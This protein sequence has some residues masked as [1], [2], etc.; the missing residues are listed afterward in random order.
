MDLVDGSN[1]WIDWKGA[2]DG[3]RAGWMDGLE[4]SHKLIGGWLDGLV[5]KEP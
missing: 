5:G 4:E 3:G 2:I 1:R